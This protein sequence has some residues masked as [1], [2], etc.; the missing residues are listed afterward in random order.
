MKI[1]MS[2]LSVLILTSHT[3][4]FAA[5]KISCED[6]NFIID[7]TGKSFQVLKRPLLGKP[8]YE[9]PYQISYKQI[10]QNSYQ[11][12]GPV[13]VYGASCEV[14]LILKVVREADKISVSKA[15]DDTQCGNGMGPFVQISCELSD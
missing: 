10:S 13:A 8:R 4:A 11:L 9:T 6:R 7:E 12:E 5:G 3:H 1:F 14:D 15:F 2:F